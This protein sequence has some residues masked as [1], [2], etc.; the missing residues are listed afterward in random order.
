M[1]QGF[2]PPDLLFIKSS[3]VWHVV[4][5]IQMDQNS[6]QKTPIH[7][8]PFYFVNSFFL[9]F[10]FAIPVFIYLLLNLLG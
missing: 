10:F 9:T 2:Q 5:E 1:A 6:L 8:L 3:S 7:R 4:I